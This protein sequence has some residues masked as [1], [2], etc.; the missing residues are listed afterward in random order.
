MRAKQRAEQSFCPLLW[1]LVRFSINKERSDPAVLK[2]HFM[3]RVLVVLALIFAAWEV[4]VFFVSRNNTAGG[5]LTVMDSLQAKGSLPDSD[6]KI[7]TQEPVATGDSLTAKMLPLSKAGIDTRNVPPQQVVEFAKTLMGTPYLY[8]S[9]DPAKGFDC[10][11]FITHVFNHFSIAV[12]RSSIDFTNVGKEVSAAEA[13]GGDLILF[14]GTDSTE[15]FVG[16]M[17]IVVSNTD[18]LRFIHSTSG[19]QKGVTITPLSSYYQG[20][21][22][23]TVL[24]FP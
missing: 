3:K 15:T 14:T 10:S 24:V 17:G 9:I 16:H 4:T 6:S 12:P 20:R 7:S 5:N 2:M 21:Y 11:G 18:T 13:R 1:G 23:K 19:R 22:V 8:G